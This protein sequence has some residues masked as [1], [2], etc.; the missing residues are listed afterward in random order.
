MQQQL[1]EKSDVALKA[2]LQKPLNSEKRT[3]SSS[4]EEGAMRL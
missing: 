4:T 2:A 3:D 1:L